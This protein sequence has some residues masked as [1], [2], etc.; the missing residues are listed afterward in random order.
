MPK[1]HTAPPAPSAPVPVQGRRL[2]LVRIRIGLDRDHTRDA[3]VLL[4]WPWASRVVTTAV[5]T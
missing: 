2:G 5:I 1:P 3:V 4:V